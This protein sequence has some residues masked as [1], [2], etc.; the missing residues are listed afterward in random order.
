MVS[1]VLILRGTLSH[2]PPRR[3]CAP[4]I[5]R[6]TTAI[7]D[8][9][10]RRFA[11]RISRGFQPDRNTHTH[12]HTHTPCVGE[13]FSYE[14]CA[15]FDEFRAF[16]LLVDLTNFRSILCREIIQLLSCL[17]FLFFFCFPSSVYSF[18]H[19]ECSGYW[20]M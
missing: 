6:E 5:L 8:E 12:T 15:K 20:G 2:P 18:R 13:S 1:K 16:R 9:T 10:I 4:A 17:S 11:A 14:S 19:S 7:R 3:P